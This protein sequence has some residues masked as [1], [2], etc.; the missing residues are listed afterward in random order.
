MVTYLVDQGKQ[1]DIIC[2]NFN[3]TFDAVSHIILQENDHHIGRQNHNIMDEWL[4]DR[5]GSTV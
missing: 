2:S 3:K 5:S 1:D 4:A